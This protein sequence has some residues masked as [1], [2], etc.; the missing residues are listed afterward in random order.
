MAYSM[1]TTFVV[2]L[3]TKE[4]AKGCISAAFGEEG[5]EK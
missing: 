1:L 2:S 4:P 5:E 3:F